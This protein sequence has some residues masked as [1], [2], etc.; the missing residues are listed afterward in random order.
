MQLIC[1]YRGT[2]KNYL[3]TNG[4]AFDKPK[5]CGN[6]GKADGLHWHGKYQRNISACDSDKLEAIIPIRRLRCSYCRLTMSLLPS[7]V[8]PRHYAHN[9]RIETYFAN[10]IAKGTRRDGSGRS[11]LLE[12]CWRRMNLHC[13]VSRH[14][15][16]NN[17]IG[18]YW[19]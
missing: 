10:K 1:E 18:T 7:F 12:S 4:E 6:C 8:Q 3:A 13:S 19:R 11:E 9:Q 15:V 2:V 16:F 5:C 17:N 14:I